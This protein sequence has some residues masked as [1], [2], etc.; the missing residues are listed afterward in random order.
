MR[1]AIFFL[2]N[3]GETCYPGDWEEITLSEIEHAIELAEKTLNWA[4]KKIV[5]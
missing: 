4:K 1:K 3:A 5:K 2:A